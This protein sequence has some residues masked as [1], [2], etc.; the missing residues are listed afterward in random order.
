M[1]PNAIIFEYLFP[2]YAANH[3]MVNGINSIY[4]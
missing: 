2:F 1:I 4:A 3:D